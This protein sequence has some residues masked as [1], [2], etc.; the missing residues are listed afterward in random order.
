MTV[1]LRR[2]S[3]VGAIAVPVGEERCVGGDSGRR[4]LTGAIR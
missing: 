4:D 1:R 2:K 3:I